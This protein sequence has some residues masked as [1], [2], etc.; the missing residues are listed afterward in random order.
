MAP[1]PRL[2][3]N[4][5]LCISVLS[6]TEI[7]C[8][9][10][11][12]NNPCINDD[13]I[14]NDGENCII[15]CIGWACEYKSFYCPSDAFKCEFTCDGTAPYDTN[16]YQGCYGINIIGGGGD[17]IISVKPGIQREQMGDAH[18]I[19][20]ID[21]DCNITCIGN[22]YGGTNVCRELSAFGLYSSTLNIISYGPSA[23]NE[24][25]IICPYSFG[26]DINCII[27]ANS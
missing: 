15:T 2:I 6:A 27:T 14:C 12:D 11:D 22:T 23:L 8:D 24:S 21:K 18:I 19:C 4:I 13:I 16:T 20:P 5:L 26:S 10:F 7:I 17:L 25:T 1:A 9:N 3:L